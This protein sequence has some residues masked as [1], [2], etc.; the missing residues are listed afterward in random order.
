[1]PIERRIVYATWVMAGNAR[2]SVLY[3]ML[4]LGSYGFISLPT[5][6]HDRA[7]MDQIQPYDLE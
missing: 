5:I 3:G 7:A 2:D 6:L 4:V 1:M